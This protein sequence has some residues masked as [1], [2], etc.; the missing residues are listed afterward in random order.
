MSKVEGWKVDTTTNPPTFTE[1][2][3]EEMAGYGPLQVEIIK[4]A[5]PQIS[6][7]RREYWFSRIEFHEGC[8]KH[9]VIHNIPIAQWREVDY[10]L[11]YYWGCK[12]RKGSWWHKNANGT[13][14][15]EFVDMASVYPPPSKPWEWCG[16]SMLFE[17]WHQ[18]VRMQ[19][20][21][22]RRLQVGDLVKFD[23]KGNTYRGIVINIR[24]RAT[25]LVG[26]AKW[27]VPPLE[28][29]KL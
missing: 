29:T 25:V 14:D 1:M 27:Y 23:Y 20:E 15:V 12:P 16:T 4:S 19:R 5:S 7:E 18:Q 9:G 28:L 13:L 26:H 2:T 22:A 10:T 8:H 21:A 6:D 24:T 17:R 11:C 3:A